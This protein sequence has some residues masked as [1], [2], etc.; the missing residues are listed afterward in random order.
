MSEVNDEKANL[1]YSTLDTLPLFKGKVSVE[2]RSKMN[3][4]F[5]MEDPALE[6][7]FLETCGRENLYGVKGHRTVGGFRASFYNALP[8][9]SVQV[10][11]DVM[12][13]F[14]QQH[15]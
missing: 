13:D 9:T 11:C 10:L 12:K 15:G 8:I 2:D 7:M 4:V 1:F 6:K 3:A 5:I 14:A